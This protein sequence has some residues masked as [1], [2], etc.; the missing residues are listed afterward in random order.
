MLGR[1]ASK[2]STGYGKHATNTGRSSGSRTLSGESGN[3]IISWRSWRTRSERSER[4]EAIMPNLWNSLA[5]ILVL[6]DLVTSLAF[7]ITYHFVAKWW[8]HPFGVSI[9]VYQII[10]SIIMFMTAVRWIVWTD[11]EP[12]IGYEM[13]R[14]L[15]FTL[16]PPTLLWRTWVLIKVQWKEGRRDI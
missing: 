7:C 2:L 11:T 13:V 9:M 14:T 4:K 5:I 8:K 15:V 16:I 1:H 6:A 3:G 12:P 10:M